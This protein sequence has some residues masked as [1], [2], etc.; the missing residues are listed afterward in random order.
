MTKQYQIKEFR[1]EEKRHHIKLIKHKFFGNDKGCGCFGKD[2]KRY[3]FVLEDGGNNLYEPIRSEA[4]K[5][6]KENNIKWWGDNPDYPTGHTVSSQTQ[7]LMSPIQNKYPKLYN[8]LKT[9]Y[10]GE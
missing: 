4:L 8:Y 5:Y 2:K 3:N 1:S 10:Y 6:F 9:R 7:K